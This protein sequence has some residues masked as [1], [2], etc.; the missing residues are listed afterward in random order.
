MRK[1][2]NLTTILRRCHEIWEI[3]FLEPS[4]PLQACNGTALP[5]TDCI[6]R[7]YHTK[8]AHKQSDY[9]EAFQ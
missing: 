9:S 6:Q 7:M 3:N 8:F 2:D 4:G 1:A 5:F